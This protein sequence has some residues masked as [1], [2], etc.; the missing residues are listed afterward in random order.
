[1]SIVF[2]LDEK[3]DVVPVR[4]A[5]EQSGGARKVRYGAVRSNSERGAPSA[6]VGRR[7]S[8]PQKS[9]FTAAPRGSVNGSTNLD[10]FLEQVIE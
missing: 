3:R 10:R 1:M 9:D 5:G 8:A 2:P 6:C 7:F 4:L